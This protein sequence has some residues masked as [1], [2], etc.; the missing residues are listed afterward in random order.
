MPLRLVVLWLLLPLPAAAQVYTWT[1]EQ[2]VQHF[3]DDPNTVPKKAKARTT[4]G[5]HVNVMASKPEEKLDS[6]AAQS[7]TETQAAAAQAQAAAAQAQAAA[8]QA[9][10]AASATAKETVE[11]AW[12]RRFREARA[13]IRELEDEIEIDRQKVEEVD[14][15][16]VNAG[17]T[18]PTGW[19]VPYA[20][21]GPPP[22]AGGGAAVGVG[23]QVAPGVHVAGGAVWTSGYSYWPSVVT[24]PCYF[25]FN[26]EYERVRDRLE[27][28]RKALVRAK[29]DL[30]DLERRAANEAVPLD[31]RR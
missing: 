24:T 11:D 25:G 15:M 2:G 28:N 19:G 4:E 20:G 10:L 13:T 27:R 8:A 5:A 31:W 7:Q 29:D 18:C 14:G 1:D 6:G 21:V 12:R 17:W 22:Y 30:K 9:Q 26:P 16:P 23:G 3:T